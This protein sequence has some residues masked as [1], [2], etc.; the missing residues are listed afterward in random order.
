MNAKTE[1]A[2]MAAGMCRTHIEN[3][4]TDLW[5]PERG[6]ATT[7]AGLVAITRMAKDI[8]GMCPVRARCLDWALAQDESHGVWGGVNFGQTRPR[9]RQKMRV[10]RGIRRAAPRERM[11]TIVGKCV[12][13]RRGGDRRRV[14]GQ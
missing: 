12:G 13:D 11:D 9:Q 7:V 14:V 8:C 6:D 2:W 10:G 4:G 3:G 5:Y 1:T